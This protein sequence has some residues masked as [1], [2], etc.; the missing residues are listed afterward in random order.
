MASKKDQKA[1]Q[2]QQVAVHGIWRRNIEA[3]KDNRA[4]WEAWVSICEN[5][6][7][8]NHRTMITAD[9]TFKEVPIELGVIWRTINLWPSTL[10]VITSRL[11][12]N[13]PRWHPKKSEM[14]NVTDAEI[15]AANAALQNIWDGSGDINQSLKKKTKRAV[16]KAWKQGSVLAYSRFDEKLDLP[17][18]DIFESWRVYSDPS[19]DELGEKQWLCIPQPKSI[20]W[21]KIN[22]PLANLL[23]D[24]LADNQAAES[25]LQQQFIKKKTG[26]NE[27]SGNTVKTIYGF[28]IIKKEWEEAELTEE[29]EGQDEHGVIQYK[30]V[31]TGKMLKREKVLIL[32]E[33]LIDRGDAP[34][35]VLHREELDYEKLDEIFTAFVPSG[36]DTMQAQPLCLT[37]VDPSKTINKMNSNAE[38]Y[39]DLFLQGRWIKTRKGLKLPV[40][41]RQ[42]EGIHANPGELQQMNMLPLPSTHFTHLQNSLD[43]FQRVSAVHGVSVGSAP[44]QIE[45]G[46][47]ISTLAHQDKQ[48]SA[49]SVD[50]F[51]MFLQS[52][53]IKSLRLMADNWSEVRTIYKY[54]EETDMT[55]EIKVIGED[56][57][58][59]L[60]KE[61]QKG[62][63]KLRRFSRVDIDIVPGEFFDDTSRQQMIVDLLQ[64]WKPGMNPIVD[65]VILS[66]FDIGIGR[67]IVRELK[68]LRNPEIMIAEANIMKLL[69]GEEVAAHPT[70]PHEFFQKFYA[71]KAKEFIEGG[72]QQSASI[73]NK[74]AQ[75]H[76]IIIKQSKGAA[77]AGTP[78]APENLDELTATQGEDFGQVQA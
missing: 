40:G 6:A 60:S 50:E 61:E 10:S 51:K 30:K 29:E 72:D 31:E 55:R 21:L 43:F 49:D 32:H 14:E 69:D 13:S 38:Q 34:Q 58:G 42:G 77:G 45:S 4:L 70:D 35:I 37:W 67:E 66:G 47:A 44:A 19:S 62:V 7:M 59:N 74:Q 39:I 54:D 2:K 5:F 9:G 78:D 68:K 46:K 26:A 20:A 64:V 16:P 33:V 25:G 56:F 48:N 36:E 53:A 76:A 63:V 1:E 17:V 27:S 18:M 65:K 22:F 71:E 28:R 75:K 11:T 52:I 3:A 41:N 73:L 12:A 15:D 57:A 24:D 8:G 23:S